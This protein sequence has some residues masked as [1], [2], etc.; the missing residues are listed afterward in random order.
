[1]LTWN[2]LAP[3]VTERLL[4]LVMETAST[5][6]WR[7]LLR[8]AKALGADVLAFQEVTAGFMAVLAEDPAWAG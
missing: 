6:R 2:V 1:M 7:A 3:S 8:E 4:G 5:G